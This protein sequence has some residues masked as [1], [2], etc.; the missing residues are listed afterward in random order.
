ME[1]K[2]DQKWNE[3]RN[4]INAIYT[5]R[6]RVDVHFKNSKPQIRASVLKRFNSEHAEA[7]EMLER[8]Q[9]PIISVPLGSAIREKAAA[10]ARSEMLTFARTSTGIKIKEGQE[11]LHDRAVEYFRLAGSKTAKPTTTPW[12]AAFISFVMS[13]AGATAS[14]FPFHI[15]HW[16]YIL[17]AASNARAGNTNASI[18]YF[19]RKDVVPRIGDLVGFSRDSEITNSDHIFARL[20]RAKGKRHFPS[21]TDIVVS[22]QPGK[23]I[24]IGGNVSDSISETQVKTITSGTDTGKIALH[25]KHFFVL[26]INV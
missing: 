16:F 22:V 25:A 21:H 1:P 7:L 11:P 13:K 14:Q 17:E 20:G 5:E 24:A 10:V 9:Q 23:L 19:D 18:V 26:R 15:G 2:G 4:V 8:Q 3:D 6:K 12:S